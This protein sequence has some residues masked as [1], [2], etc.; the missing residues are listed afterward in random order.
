MGQVVFVHMMDVCDAK[1]ERGEEDDFRGGEET[2]EM[3]GNEKRPE[4][5]FFG[6]GTLCRLVREPSRSF[7]G[8][9]GEGTN[10]DVIAPADPAAEAFMQAAAPDPLPP[11]RFDNA[12]FKERAGKEERGQEEGFGNVNDGYGV[13]A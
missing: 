12:F 5:Q 11:S 1:V 7:G 4:D 3:Q 13:P 9:G 8:G 2:E 6:C 10:S